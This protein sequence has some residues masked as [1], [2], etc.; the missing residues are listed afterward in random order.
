MMLPVAELFMGYEAM[1]M[2]HKTTALAHVAGTNVIKCNSAIAT[3]RAQLSVGVHG[4]GANRSLV[5]V[6]H[7]N[8]VTM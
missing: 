8:P 6:L 5:R 4:A 2:R 7:G 3:A 1:L